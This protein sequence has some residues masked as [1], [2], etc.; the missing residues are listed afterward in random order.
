MKTL[1]MMMT[2]VFSSMMLMACDDGRAE[3]AGEKIDKAME[4]AG[5][6]ISNAAEDAGN[7]IEDACENVTDENC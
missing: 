6:N 5:E 2:L 4:D 7:A 3:N 1:L